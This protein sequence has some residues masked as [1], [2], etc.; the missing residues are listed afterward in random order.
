M[1]RYVYGRTHARTRY[2]AVRS[3]ARVG[4]GGEGGRE[5]GR[6]WWWR[7]AFNGR[8]WV[9]RCEGGGEGSNARGTCRV[10]LSS[11]CVSTC[12]CPRVYPFHSL[13]PSPHRATSLR[14]Q[15]QSRRERWAAPHRR[16]RTYIA[17]L[18]SL[19]T[20]TYSTSMLPSPS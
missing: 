11:F 16:I 20:S 8:C 10:Y 13:F 3:G 2:R 1:V 9:G 6:W 14:V 17:G 12:V 18:D 15:V 4:D 7:N 5:G 19:D